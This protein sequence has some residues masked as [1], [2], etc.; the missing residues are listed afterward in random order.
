MPGLAPA[1]AFFDTLNHAY[2]AVSFTME[3][4]ENGMLP[5][6]GVQLLNRAPCVEIK[7]YV[8]PTNTGLLLHDHSHVDSHYKQDLLVTMLDHAHQLS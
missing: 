4:E 2:S 6:L 7:V 8:K 5:S 1:T 3:V